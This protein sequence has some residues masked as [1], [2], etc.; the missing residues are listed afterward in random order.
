MEMDL[1]VACMRVPDGYAGLSH[2]RQAE[3]A[4]A[5]LEEEWPDEAQQAAARAEAR[6]AATPVPGLALFL[7]PFVCMPPC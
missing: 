4:A 6:E 1:R 7:S 2:W 5:L 3:L